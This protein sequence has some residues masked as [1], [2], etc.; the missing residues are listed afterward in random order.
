MFNWNWGTVIKVCV[1]VHS[2]KV[3]SGEVILRG[4]WFV[5]DVAVFTEIIVAVE[6]KGVRK[7]LNMG[8]KTVALNV[9][10]PKAYTYLKQFSWRASHFRQ[11]H[12]LRFESVLAHWSILHVVGMY[13]RTNPWTGFNLSVPLSFSPRLRVDCSNMHGIARLEATCLPLCRSVES[14]EIFT[15]GDGNQTSL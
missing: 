14:G 1:P 3:S 12:D 4:K 13:Q 7:I 2:C 6:W 15:T 11:Y 10:S 9:P 5:V 8:C